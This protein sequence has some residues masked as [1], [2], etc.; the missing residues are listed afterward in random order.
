[1]GVHV[2]AHSTRY[3][4]DLQRPEV[5]GAGQQCRRGRRCR[6]NARTSRG[7]A[8]SRTASNRAKAQTFT[9]M[10]GAPNRENHTQEEERREEIKAHWHARVRIRENGCTLRRG[11]MEKR[12]S[13]SRE[14][15]ELGAWRRPGQSVCTAWEGA[16]ATRAGTGAG[17][18]RHWANE[19]S[20]QSTGGWR[21]RGVGGRRG[22]RAAGT[23]DQE[24]RA[25]GRGRPPATGAAD[26]TRA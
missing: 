7:R 8:R 21:S 25:G 20:G 23:S 2:R 4:P 15:E 11:K 13:E 6:A 3:H 17:G 10:Q 19:R 5:L 24:G 18:A 1:M 22:A 16:R 26:G 12:R 9:T 14:P